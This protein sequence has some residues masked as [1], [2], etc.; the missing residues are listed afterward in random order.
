[1]QTFK[2]QHDWYLEDGCEI[3]DVEIFLNPDWWCN[4]PNEMIVEGQR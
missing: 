3:K 1:M 4:S 2:H